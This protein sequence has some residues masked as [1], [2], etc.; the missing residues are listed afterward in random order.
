MSTY[1]VASPHDCSRLRKLPLGLVAVLLLSASAALDQSAYSQ[2]ESGSL[3]ENVVRALETGYFDKDFRENQL[4]EIVER[5]RQRAYDAK[6]L[7]EQR[8][9]VQAMLSNIPA[10]HMGLLSISSRDRLMG[11]LQNVIAPT[12]GF[13]LI[14]YDG[15]HYAH[16]VLEKG[17]AERAGLRRGDRIVM[18][19]DVLVDDNE[20]L[21]WTTDDAYLPDPP[22]RALLC[23]ADDVIKLVIERGWGDVQIIE[24]KA[25][26][27]SAF[28]AAKASARVIEHEGKR[29]GYIHFWLI[30]MTGVTP[31]L[32]EK[33]NGEFV[34][35]DALVIDLR[36]RGGNG[37][38]I[39][40]LLRTLQGEGS[41][42][43]GPVVA[44]I[45]RNARS[46]KEVIAYE[47]RKQNIALLVG[48]RT[49]GAAI[50]ASF[51][52]VGHDTVLMFPKF[53]LG[54]Y[55][56]Y[57]E[58]IGVEPDVAV[59][60]ARPYSRGADPVLEVGLLEAARLAGEYIRTEIPRQDV[61]RHEN[62]E[63]TG[64]L[65]GTSEILSRM[66][67]ALGGEDAVR[68]HT[69]MT[70]TGTMDI[71]G[72]FE[73]TL[74]LHAAAPNY[75]VMNLTLPGMGDFRNGYD[76]A[77]AWRDDPQR[78]KG[79]M[80]G[81]ER[82]GMIEQAEFYASLHYEKQ[83]ETIETVGIEQFAGRSCY[84]LIMTN[85]AGSERTLFID[86]ETFLEAGSRSTQPGHM[87]GE[88]VVTTTNEEYQEFDGIMVPT[89]VKQN[90]GDMQEMTTTYTKVTFDPID[91]V[92]FALPEN[93]KALLKEE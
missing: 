52:D 90:V 33:L 11:E 43:R 66:I 29:I 75:F 39:Q 32:R 14:E 58:G 46:A 54:R 76:G 25:D 7:H 17:P 40:A 31:L 36:G 80:E 45:N 70:L 60:D 10:S 91:P 13:E 81:K 77:T 71:A 9:V 82:K 78:G 30:H 85:A 72:M 26:D 93:I 4:P 38:A 35:C 18:I 73:G 28:E 50:P 3:Y 34:D 89:R 86:T 74:T 24:I 44:L 63:I 20:R 37:M 42:W 48:E 55:T 69:S 56:E 84:V 61:V 62:A 67:D 53:K 23:E 27:Y 16:G 79:I 65:P 12:F 49:A 1:P 59:E 41:N 6:T 19:D 57:I 87:G 2:K 22:V 64:K 51:E 21:D 5:Y 15:K 92:V 8:E 68:A 88:V 47:M 83:Y